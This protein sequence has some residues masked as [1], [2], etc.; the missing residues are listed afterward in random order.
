VVHNYDSR[1]WKFSDY[2]I[3]DLGSG[4]VRPLDIYGGLGALQDPTGTIV[5]ALGTDN[6][7]RVGPRSGGEPHLLC[8]HEGEVKRFDISPDSRWIASATDAEIRV[9]PMPDVSQPPLHTLPHDEL[10]AKLDT[11][12]NLRAVRDA[13]S[14]SGWKLEIGPFPGWE[15]APTW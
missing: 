9:W 4:T 12:T 11:Y 8:G 2:R 7:V 15:T 3:L 6:I 5:V 14:P 13:A 10:M 1:E